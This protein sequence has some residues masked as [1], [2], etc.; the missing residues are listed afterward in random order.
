MAREMQKTVV[1]CMKTIVIDSSVFESRKVFTETVTAQ[2]GSAFVVN[3]AITKADL[4]D[5]ILHLKDQYLRGDQQ[6]S[7]KIAH[8]TGLVEND[9]WYLSQECQIF[10]GELLTEKKVKYFGQDRI[11]K[12][13]TLKKRSLCL[14]TWHH[15]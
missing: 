12:S 14:I 10:K 4:S 15:A 11:P 3:G 13:M 7:F 2:F 9:Y 8:F 1:H 6:Q 5:Y